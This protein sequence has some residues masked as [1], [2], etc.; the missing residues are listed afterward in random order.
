[1]RQTAPESLPR[2]VAAYAVARAVPGLLNLLSIAIYTRML[3]PGD[4][5]HY[6][7]VVSA[8]ILANSVFFFWLQVGLKRFVPRYEQSSGPLLAT[9]VAAFI[10]LSGAMVLSVGTALLIGQSDEWRATLPIALA[11]VVSQ[12]WFELN[13]QL[14]AAKVEPGRYGAMASVRAGMS[15]LTGFTLVA[16]GATWQGP[17]WGLAMAGIVASVLLG[18]NAWRGASPFKA[19]RELL[20]RLGIYGVPLSLTS[21]LAFASTYL[22]RFML[23]AFIDKAAAGEYAAAFDLISFGLQTAMMMVN[24]AA[25]PLAVRLLERKGQEAASATLAHQSILLLAI[26]LPIAVGIGLV[27]NNFAQVVLGKGFSETGATVMPWIASAALFVGLRTFYLDLAFQLGQR[28]V[29]QIWVTGL[30][31]G[32]ALFLN[33]ALIPSFG[34]TGAACASVIAALT[35]M[36]ASYWLGRDVFRMPVAWLDYGRVVGATAVMALGLV[37][38]DDLRGPTALGVQL[39]VGILTYGLG[40]TIFNVANSRHR[41]LAAGGRLLSAFR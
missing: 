3:S 1:M 31:A 40:L 11:V 10:V 18:R 22:D 33:L 5:G 4:Y 23:A 25:F 7:L 39:A 13:L 6:A 9:V 37:C 17:L 14:A 8:V 19:D 41:L 32:V 21:L 27:A 28:T 2:Y 16:L 29:Q 15:L 36:F 34:V 26:G 24:L 12:G 30:A 38:V 35:S 20:R